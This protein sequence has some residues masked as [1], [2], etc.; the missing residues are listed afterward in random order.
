MYLIDLMDN[1][2]VNIINDNTEYRFKAQPFT[3]NNARFKIVT[4]PV[5]SGG[6]VATSDEGAKT[7][8]LDVKLNVINNT[9]FVDNHTASNGVLLIFS[10]DGKL[11]SKNSFVS[12]SSNAFPL[13]LQIG[14]YIAKCVT[15][16]ETVTQQF[17][18]K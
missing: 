13:D 3:T 8:L 4:S 5:V 11:I 16:T 1:T 6:G 15:E 14:T 7:K 18:I 2:V 17:I 12:S 10:T 9:V